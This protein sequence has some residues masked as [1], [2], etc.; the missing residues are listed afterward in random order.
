MGEGSSQ[1]LLQKARSETVQSLG[2]D[3]ISELGQG[4]GAEN[5]SEV[6]CWEAWHTMAM[7]WSEG[8]G[9]S[10]RSGAVE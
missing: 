7:R 6:W 10:D 4:M 3:S 2:P 9:K 8:H 5:G 1:R